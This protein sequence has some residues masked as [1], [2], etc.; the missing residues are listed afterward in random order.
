MPLTFPNVGFLHCGGQVILPN[1]PYI[2]PNVGFCINCGADP[3]V[4]AGRPRP[5]VRSKNQVLPQPGRPA[6]GP[7]ADEGVRPTKEPRQ[8]KLDIWPEGRL[9]LPHGRGS[10]KYACRA[11]RV[12]KRFWSECTGYFSAAPNLIIQ[13]CACGKSKWQWAI[14]PAAAFHAPTGSRRAFEPGRGPAKSAPQRGPRPRL[15]HCRMLPKAG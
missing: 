4:C 15:P 10:V 2:S 8:N 13:A 1:A 9:T 5:A 7:A 11:A 12:S 3:L 6:R 14:L